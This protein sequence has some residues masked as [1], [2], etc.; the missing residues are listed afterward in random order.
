MA[1]ELIML[2]ETTD[3]IINIFVDSQAAL[4]ALE[5]PF[6]KSATVK[7]CIESLAKLSNQNKVILQWVPGHNDIE[8]NELADL[9]ARQG[10]SKHISWATKIE[11]PTAH[12]NELITGI[13]KDLCK[14]KWETSEKGKVTKAIWSGPD[15]KSTTEIL[16]LK[17]PTLKNLMYS[18]TGHWNIGK[19]AQKLGI[20]T[21]SECKC[22]IPSKDIDPFHFWCDCPTI[23]MLRFEIF[24]NYFLYEL[25]KVEVFKLGKLL[26]YIKKSK[27]F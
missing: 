18:V 6:I 16:S 14:R 9:L 11:C 2:N 25:P 17:R 8:G 20:E 26:E 7:R 15:K 24:N 1:C 4:K 3:R 12:I 13:T 21:P 23:A 22:G 27:W 5:A 19:H 10:S